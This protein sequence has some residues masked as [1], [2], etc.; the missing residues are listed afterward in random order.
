MLSIPRQP[1]PAFSCPVDPQQPNY[2]AKSEEFDEHA[3]CIVQVHQ[4]GQVCMK[5]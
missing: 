1:M 5:L 2:E 3:T 4:C